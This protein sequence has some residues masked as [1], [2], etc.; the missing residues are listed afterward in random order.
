MRPYE[1]RSTRDRSTTH[2]LQIWVSTKWSSISQQSLFF[3]FVSISVCRCLATGDASLISVPA[4]RLLSTHLTLQFPAW[5]RIRYVLPYIVIRPVIVGDGHIIRKNRCR[6]KKMKT[7]LRIRT[8]NEKV[9]IENVIHIMGEK[10]MKTTHSCTQ[11]INRDNTRKHTQQMPAW[12]NN[13]IKTWK[14]S[15]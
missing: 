7:K 13:T 14:T 6:R 1:P 2:N 11:N 8:K 5:Y 10:A 12:V 9:H 3:N 15:A 4:K